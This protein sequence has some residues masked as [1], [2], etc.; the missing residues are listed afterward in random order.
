MLSTSFIHRLSKERPT[1]STWT[2]VCLSAKIAMSVVSNVI[3]STFYG[4]KGGNL[5]LEPSLL[6]LDQHRLR[7]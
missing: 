4:T 7:T 2:L 3:D 1:T 5:T 6:R